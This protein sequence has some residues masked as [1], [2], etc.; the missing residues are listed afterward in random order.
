MMTLASSLGQKRVKFT[1]PRAPVQLTKV[2]VHSSPF[3]RSEQAGKVDAIHGTRSHAWLQT[4][5]ST[6]VPGSCLSVLHVE[7]KISFCPLTLK[8]SILAQWYQTTYRT[9]NGDLKNNTTNSV[10][11]A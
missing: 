6:W 7:L 1:K 10:L 2:S 8:S 9:A 5:A 3:P 4:Q 11:L